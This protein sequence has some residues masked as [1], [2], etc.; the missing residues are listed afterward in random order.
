MAKTYQDKNAKQTI[1][2]HGISVW[3]KFKKLYQHLQGEDSFYEYPLPTW[4]YDYKDNLLPILE[5]NLQEIKTYLIYHDCGKPFCISE[6][7][8]GQHFQNH[9]QISKEIF[10]QHFNNPMIADLIGNDM[11]CHITK[12]K[13][14]EL[15]LNIPNI[16]I[17]LCS[18][19]A[20]LH[21]N[22]L[23][24]G[25]FQSDSFKIKFKNFNKLGARILQHKYSTLERK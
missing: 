16:E 9:A 23:M 22:A 25:G 18:A 6:D 17:L 19:L 7:E 11:L 10:S 20:E 8:Q 4:I 3:F 24:F 14:Y 13:D 1:L 21:S 5:Q 12:A 2:M 15:L